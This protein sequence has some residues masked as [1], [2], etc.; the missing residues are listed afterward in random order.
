MKHTECKDCELGKGDCGHHFRMDGITN[1]DVASLSVSDPYGNCM[2]FK[3]KA[4]PQGDLI[5][6][7][8][9]KK[10]LQPYLEIDGKGFISVLNAIELIDNAPTFTDRT[11]EV[12]SLQNTIAKLVDGIAEN[13]RPKGKWVYTDDMYETLVCS[14]CGIDTKDYIRHN[15]CPNCGADM[16]DKAIN[17]ESKAEDCT[18]IVCGECVLGD[19]DSCEDLRGDTE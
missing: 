12:L 2:F 5:S 19:C 9:L 11:E 17:G 7:E 4:K 10:A 3:S 16:R 15:F 6:R 13:A 8:A 14:V 18:S 1:Y